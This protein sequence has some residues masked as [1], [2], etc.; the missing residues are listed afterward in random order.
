MRNNDTT[1]AW[2]SGKGWRDGCAAIPSAARAKERPFKAL[3]HHLCSALETGAFAKRTTGAPH[4]QNPHTECK[5][6][7]VEGDRLGT[8]IAEPISDDFPRSRE[9]RQRNER[10]P[11]HVGANT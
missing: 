5:C 3:T 2:H 11:S 7:T 9:P 6:G 1:K 8:E 4:G 10:H